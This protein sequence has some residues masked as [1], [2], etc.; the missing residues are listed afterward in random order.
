MVLGRFFDEDHFQRANLI[1]RW[2]H[3]NVFLLC[4]AV[5]GPGEGGVSPACRDIAIEAREAAR[6]ALH[7]A[8][9]PSFRGRLRSARHTQLAH[10]AWSAILSLKMTAILPEGVDMAGLVA[11]ASDMAQ[12]LYGCPDS[13]QFSV[14]IRIALERFRSKTLHGAGAPVRAG[15]PAEVGSANTSPP[16]TTPSTTPSDVHA[17]DH[18]AERRQRSEVASPRKGLLLP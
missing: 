7:V 1:L 16:S 5:L 8:L 15:G 11:S 18:E 2:C 4:P 3:L 9:E 13:Q 14:T 12:L 6:G 10:F 17:H